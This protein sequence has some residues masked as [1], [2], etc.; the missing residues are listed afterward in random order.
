[1]KR[2]KL[3]ELRKTDFTK[4]NRYNCITYKG[5]SFIVSIGR[6]INGIS[7]F[8]Y[9][10]NQN[11]NGYGLHGHFYDN[12]TAFKAFIKMAVNVKIK[13]AGINKK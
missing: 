6:D 2:V 5:Y 8:C 9:D 3:T 12:I 13:L 10:C 11:I 1:M 7:C 4:E